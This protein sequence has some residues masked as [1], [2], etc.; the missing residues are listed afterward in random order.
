MKKLIGTM[1]LELGM[2]EH[3]VQ[4]IMSTAPNR[5]KVYKIPKRTGGWREIAQPAREV[6]LLQRCLV[7][8][9]LSK[10]PVH[11]SAT[12]YKIGHSI[13]DNAKPHVENGPILKL[14]LKE[15][16]PSLR[17]R[18]WELYCKRNGCLEE[19]IDI[20]LS[21]R[22]LF[23]RAK[24]E[25]VLR[26]A[27][28]AP[29]SPILSNILMH[30]FDVKIVQAIEKD[31]VVYTRYADDMTFSAP[32]T[33]YLTGVIKQVARVIRTLDSP[34]LDLNVKKTVCAT[35]KY[36]RSITGLILSND[37]RVTIGRDKKRSTRA[38]VH[39]AVRG[40]L[41]ASELQILAGTL[42]Y[43][44]AVEPAFLGVLK[45]KYGSIE[46]EKIQR[47]KRGERLQKLLE[48]AVIGV[49]D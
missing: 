30:E 46:V 16:F 4:S 35:K 27:I 1:S 28:G 26:L 34:M 10:L 37:G 24:G 47:T 49:T 15:F 29:S 12:A 32:R 21:A 38:A 19:E 25:S 7:N 44:N 43:I 13:A 5:Y 33:G 41:T 42:A 8:V 45:N 48:P 40:L 14:D 11:P 23:R 18:D 39:R 20:A 3:E 2:R 6:K 22:L 31:H 36:R 17:S 9:L